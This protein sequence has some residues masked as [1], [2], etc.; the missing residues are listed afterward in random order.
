MNARV[1]GTRTVNILSAA[2]ASSMVTIF[3]RRVSGFIVV[4][5]SCF[6]IISPRP[7]NR[8]IVT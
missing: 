7:L 5:Q 8:W 4:S 3:M 6:G 1:S 2:V